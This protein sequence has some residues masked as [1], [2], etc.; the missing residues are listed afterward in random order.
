METASV[1]NKKRERD[2]NRAKEE[3]GD[4]EIGNVREEIDVGK[5]EWKMLHNIM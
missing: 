5:R 4:R 1:Y 3:K 2:R